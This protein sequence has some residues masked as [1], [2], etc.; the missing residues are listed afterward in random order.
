MPQLET[1]CALC[2]TEEQDETHLFFKCIYAKKVWK[3]IG[4]WWELTPIVHNSQ[5]LMKGLSKIKVSSTTK[6]IAF[7]VTIPTIYSIWRTRN[8]QDFHKHHMTPKQTVHMTQEQIRHRVSFLQSISKND[9]YMD[10]ILNRH[11]KAL[12]T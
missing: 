1:K 5:Q 4:G 12:Q 8:H 7:A 6:R 9:K 2:T 3:E 11:T 10:S